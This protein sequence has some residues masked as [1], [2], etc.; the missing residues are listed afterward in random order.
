MQWLVRNASPH[1]ALF[2]HCK[3]VSFMAYISFL[4][5]LMLDSGHGGQTKDLDGD[6][7]DGFD[8]GG[9]IFR[10]NFKLW[11]TSIMFKV[12]YPVSSWLCDIDFFLT[13]FL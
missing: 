2:F 3:P 11:L 12:I 5:L 4:F 7:A 8:E 9:S 10:F 13:F 6:E 1:D